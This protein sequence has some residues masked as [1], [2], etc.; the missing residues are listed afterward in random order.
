MLGWNEPTG[1]EDSNEV[2]EYM[3]MHPKLC[4]NAIGV[5]AHQFLDPAFPREYS[6]VVW[7]EIAPLV[8]KKFLIVLTGCKLSY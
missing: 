6:C 7:D 5:S 8:L 4:P 3:G 1:P 2:L